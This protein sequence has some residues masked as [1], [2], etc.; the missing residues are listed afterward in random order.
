MIQK[1]TL[2]II[3]SAIGGAVGFWVFARFTSFNGRFY[4]WSPP[5][6]EYEATTLIGAAIALTLIIIGLVTITKKQQE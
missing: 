1:K 6:S 3:Y 4:T 5:F 2:G